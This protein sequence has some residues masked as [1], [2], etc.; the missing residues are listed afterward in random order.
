MKKRFGVS[1]DDSILKEINIFLKK[2]GYRSRSHLIEEL[3]TGWIRE[4]KWEKG[5]R[6]VYGILI[7]VYEH[8]KREISKKLL[9]KGHKHYDEIISTLHIHIDERNCLEISVL[10]GKPFRIRKISD[11]IISTKGVKYGKLLKV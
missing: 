8:E 4:R 10:R 5:K 1:I 9:E 11:E 2:G 7:M 3:L 6:E